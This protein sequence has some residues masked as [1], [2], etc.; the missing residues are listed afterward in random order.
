VHEQVRAIDR[1]RA[2][3]IRDRDLESKRLGA[4]GLNGMSQCH[5]EHNPEDPGKSVVL[6]ERL[7]RDTDDARGF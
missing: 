2:E 3:A 4:S 1:L 7:P 6:H 5:Q